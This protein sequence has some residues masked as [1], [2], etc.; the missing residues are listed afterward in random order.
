MDGDSGGAGLAEGDGGVT[1]IELLLD[2]LFATAH[3]KNRRQGEI[4]V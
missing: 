3:S 2:V 4:R 1:L